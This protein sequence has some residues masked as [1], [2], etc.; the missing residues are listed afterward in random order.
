VRVVNTAAAPT[1]FSVG[2]FGTTMEFS[3]RTDM[4]PED[5]LNILMRAVIFESRTGEPG[6]PLLEEEVLQFLM[7]Y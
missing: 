4:E 2:S 5:I 1:T 6:Y 7:E 3:S